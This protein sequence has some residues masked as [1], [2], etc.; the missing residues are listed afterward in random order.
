MEARVNFTKELNAMTKTKISPQRKGELRW[1]RL[2]V[3]EKDGKLQQAKN[4]YDIAEI[5]G[6]TDRSRGYG[7]V[8]NLISKG[9]ISETLREVENGKFIYEY[10]L[11]KRPLFKCGK[12]SNKCILEATE[13]KP[14]TK[15]VE[16]SKSVITIEVSGMVIKA[17]GVSAE[18][19]A[20]IIKNIK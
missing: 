7:W 17:E 14:E 18:Y 9:N 15:P 12:G 2:E 5:A 20:T 8:A 6:I 19:I 4:R 16:T 10:H 3:S 13:T 11:T 1:E